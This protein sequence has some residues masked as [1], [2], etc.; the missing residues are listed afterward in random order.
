MENQPDEQFTLTPGGRYYFDLSAMNIPGTLNSA[1][2]DGTLHYVPFTYVGTVEAYK[3]TSAMATTEEYAQQNKYAHSL[4]VADYAVTLK[5]NWNNL[6]TASLIFGKIM[7]AAAWTIPCAHRLWEVGLPVQAIQSAVRPKAMSGTQCWTRT[8][9]MSKLER[10]IFV[11][12]GHIKL[13]I[14]VSCGSR[15]R[16][17]P[18]LELLLCCVLRPARRFPPRP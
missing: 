4:F 5:V 9:A 14:V 18:L 13:R 10:H 16:F 6:D 8:A 15:V 11:G 17:G 2:P 7:P 12:A 1:L 3:L